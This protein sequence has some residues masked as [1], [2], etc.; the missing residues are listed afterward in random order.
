MLTFLC[1]RADLMKFFF[2]RIKTVPCITYNGIGQQ[3]EQVF[4]SNYC[5]LTLLQYI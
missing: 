4:I 5:P 1:E 3:K 2:L